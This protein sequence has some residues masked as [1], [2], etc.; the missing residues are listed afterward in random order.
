MPTTLADQEEHYRILWY[1]DPGTT[2]TTSIASAAKMGK[3]I[4]I[5]VDNGLKKKALRRFGIPLENIEL[6]IDHSKDEVTW[7]LLERIHRDID[8]RLADGEDIFA[9]AWDT[10]T[11]TADALLDPAVE[12]S[13]VKSHRKGLSDRTEFEIHLEDRGIVVAQMQKYLRRLHRLPCHL[14]LGAHQRRD[15]DKDSSAVTIGPAMSPS[16]VTNFSGWMDCIL[17]LSSTPFDNDPDLIDGME[18]SALA[19]PEGVITAKDRFGLLPKRLVN[20]TADRVI[21]YLDETLVSERDPIQVA[22]RKRRGQAVAMA[23]AAGNEPTET[24]TPAESVE[25]DIKEPD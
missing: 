17:H 24:A 21:G 1:G 23:K 11:K 12:A 14:L 3:V 25:V 13:V 20:P 2:K 4:Y 5:D 15:V 8:A 22:A 18:V 9:V 7:G 10:T 6:A 16:V 19:R